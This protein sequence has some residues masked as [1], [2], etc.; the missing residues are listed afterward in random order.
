MRRF[1]WNFAWQMNC[2]M[3]ILADKDVLQRSFFARTRR[4]TPALACV[5]APAMMGTKRAPVWRTASPHRF[6]IARSACDVAIFAMMGFCLRIGSK[7]L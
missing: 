1:G 7:R 6:A 4:V 3:P 2:E 5:S